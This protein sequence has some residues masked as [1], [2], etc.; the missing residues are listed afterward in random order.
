MNFQKI[1][2]S[3]C[4]V[5]I[6]TLNK[7]NILPRPAVSN[8]LIVVKLKHSFKFRGHVYFEPVHPHM[9]KC[10]VLAYLKWHKKGLSSEELIRFFDIVEIKDQN[11]KCYQKII[12]DTKETIGNRNLIYIIQNI[13]QL[14][15]P[16]TCTELHQM[17]QL[18]FLRF[19]I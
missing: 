9:F 5:P 4:N 1:K 14:K 11:R 2:K 3:I 13:L 12:S 10:Q 7:G 19:Q 18:L 17:R 8:D 16:Q 6:E 15:I